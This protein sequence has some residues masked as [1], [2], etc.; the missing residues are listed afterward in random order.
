MSRLAALIQSGT[1]TPTHSQSAG[2]GP[3]PGGLWEEG[4]HRFQD[5]LL[6]LFS[7]GPARDR[8]PRPRDRLS[9][10]CKPGETGLLVEAGGGAGRGRG[11]AV[12]FAASEMTGP[13][14]FFRTQ[15]RPRFPPGSRRAL[16]LAEGCGQTGMVLRIWER[17][18][19][20]GPLTASWQLPLV[21]GS[22][23]GGKGYPGGDRRGQ[24]AVSWGKWRLA[25][26]W[27]FL[28]EGCDRGG[29]SPR[30][31]GAPQAT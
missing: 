26:P 4:D 18:L 28:G 2:E 11:A 22:Y 30:S 13:G 6:P 9:P 31:G 27:N 8:A 16:T 25:S 10:R 7:P 23:S 17:P 3:C 24:E 14:P 15:S 21:Q 12:G 19:F 1:Y 29:G 5:G 20:T